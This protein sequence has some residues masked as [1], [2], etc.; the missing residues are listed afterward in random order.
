MSETPDRPV[1]ASEQRREARRLAE[2]AERNRLAAEALVLADALE[3]QEEERRE[4]VLLEEERMRTEQQER[5][6]RE[7][8]ERARREEERFQRM[9]EEARLEE[10]AE[11]ARFREQERRLAEE[12]LQRQRAQREQAEALLREQQEANRREAEAAQQQAQVASVGPPDLA[13]RPANDLALFRHY[14]R[15][16]GR[17]FTIGRELGSGTY[18]SVFEATKAG[19]PRRLVLKI[20]RVSQ[21][22]NFDFEGLYALSLGRQMRARRAQGETHIMPVLGGGYFERGIFAGQIFIV[23]P[24][25]NEGSLYDLF[26]KKDEL[27]MRPD[28]PLWAWAAPSRRE[29]MLQLLEGL[30][31]MHAFGYAHNDMKPLNILVHREGDGD[32]SRYLLRLADFGLGCVDR[33][34]LRYLKLD[35]IAIGTPYYLSPEYRRYYI[36][37]ARPQLTDY[38]RRTQFARE[39]PD[40]DRGERARQ[41]PDERN[42]FVYA[43][44]DIAAAQANDVFGLGLVFFEAFYQR[45]HQDNYPPPPFIDEFNLSNGRT[46]RLM[47]LEVLNTLEPDLRIRTTLIGMLAQSPRDRFT[48]EEA[49]RSMQ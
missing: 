48:A 41:R 6:I 4:Q 29:V 16:D 24:L 30:A 32:Q 10:Q 21:Y 26:K 35:C 25:M 33:K 18:G 17:E 5:E 20:M 34:I 49:L 27:E 37:D 3:R 8:E 22:D 9:Q 46:R 23:Y 44:K 7:Q 47:H 11:Q 31:T 45:A 12:A 28:Y 19:D 13:Q 39:N 43:E 36:A 42:T 40:L 1:S 38:V 2:Q 14:F 15:S